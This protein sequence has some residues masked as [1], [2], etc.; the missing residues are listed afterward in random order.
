MRTGGSGGGGGTV[1]GGVGGIGSGGSGGTG[2]GGAG[3]SAT[4]GSTGSGATKGG[5]T[6]SGGIAGSGGDAGVS[7]GGAGG[8]GTGGVSGTGAGGSGGGSGATD[9][10]SGC[11]Y[12]GGID[13]LVVA[14]A[15]AQGG[16]CVTLVLVDS[17]STKD[18]GLTISSP[19]RVGFAARWPA[20]TAPCTTSL[21]PAGASS[22]SSGTGTVTV[23]GSLGM[24][25]TIDVDAVLSFPQGDSGVSES[26]PLQA[27]G[28]V[29]AGNCAPA[30]FRPDASSG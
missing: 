5:S 2:T 12:I 25:P 24:S 1:T 16:I 4:G 10:Y 6:G 21:P 14:K 29:A 8:T 27:R 28:V 13:R 9:V 20:S 11:A 22:A 23:N 3:G 15:S 19:W 30:V 26:E 7:T 18:F 17:G